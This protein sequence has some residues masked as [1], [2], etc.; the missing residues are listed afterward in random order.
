MTDAAD[1]PAVGGPAPS[2]ALLSPCPLCRYVND[3]PFRLRPRDE[4]LDL[5]PAAQPGARE[6]PAI[7]RGTETERLVQEARKHTA[8]RHVLRC[9]ERGERL[10]D[11]QYLQLREV[12]LQPTSWASLQASAVLLVVLWPQVDR[13]VQDAIDYYRLPRSV[14]GDLGR[15]VSFAVDGGVTLARPDQIELDAKAPVVSHFERLFCATLTW[16]IYGKLQLQPLVLPAEDEAFQTAVEQEWNRVLTHGNGY[17]GLTVLPL[18]SIPDMVRYQ[19]LGGRDRAVSRSMANYLAW[20]VDTFPAPIQLQVPKLRELGPKRWLMAM[21]EPLVTSCATEAKRR[22]QWEEQIWDP[23]AQGRMEK[24]FRAVLS[25]AIDEY[26]FM[27]G[28]GDGSFGT[29]GGLGL[30]SSPHLRERVDRACEALGVSWRSRDL[31]HISVAWYLLSRLRGHLREHYRPPARDS[32]QILSLDMPYVND[33]GETVTLKD[34][35]STE[36]WGVDGYV[37]N[38]G[39]NVGVLWAHEEEG[40]RY[41]YVEEMASLCG[42][43]AD[44][45]RHWDRSGE[46]RALRLGDVARGLP[47]RVRREWRVYPYTPEMVDRIRDLARRKAGRAGQMPER[48]YTRQ[49]AARALNVSAK[50]LQRWEKEGKARPEWQGGRAVYSSEEVWRLV[51]ELRA[52]RRR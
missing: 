34:M 25:R 26:D 41:A 3:C 38:V 46:I 42:V 35:L 50:T 22:E 5:W 23:K 28:K 36:G 32:A 1:G 18:V 24:Q 13:Y 44:Q 14:V 30:E 16:F 33:D 8:L 37:A 4:C 27:Y 7:Y 31:V 29:A 20:Q 21:F 10:S 48:S 45:L 12:A 2:K 9:W 17:F 11:E 52:E 39:S 40:V 47:G 19:Q 6:F 49:Q 51:T 15:A 43:S